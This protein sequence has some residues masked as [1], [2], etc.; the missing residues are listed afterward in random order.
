[1]AQ[2][3]ALPRRGDAGA[4]GFRGHDHLR[5]RDHCVVR[6]QLAGFAGAQL[7]IYR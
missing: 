2:R 5:A 6:T 4:A 1:M 3:H 7:G